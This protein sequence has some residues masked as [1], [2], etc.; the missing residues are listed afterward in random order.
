MD[1]RAAWVRTQGTLFPLFDPPPC[2]GLPAHGHIEL[3]GGGSR[4]RLTA[5]LLCLTVLE[6]GRS[7][8][9]PDRFPTLIGVAVEIEFW[10]MSH[11]RPSNGCPVHPT[12]F[13][14]SGTITD[15]FTRPVTYSQTNSNYDITMLPPSHKLGDDQ[16]GEA[17]NQIGASVLSTLRTYPMHTSEDSRMSIIVIAGSSPDICFAQNPLTA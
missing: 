15:K 16:V 11:R 1:M 17:I 6:R 7:T 14:D 10:D 8:R 9:G 3:V 5:L 2:A 4:S 12:P 13:K